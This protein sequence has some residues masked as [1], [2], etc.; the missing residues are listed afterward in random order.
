VRLW[1]ADEPSCPAQA[2]KT[3]LKT[4]HGPHDPL[5]SRDHRDAVLDLTGSSSIA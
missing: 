5:L 3:Y 1:H 4:S 2:P